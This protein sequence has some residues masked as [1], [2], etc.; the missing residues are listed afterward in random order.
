MAFVPLIGDI[1]MAAKTLQ[2]TRSRRVVKKKEGIMSY[3][4]SNSKSQAASA[5]SPPI[6]MISLMR[7]LFCKPFS[8]MAFANSSRRPCKESRAYQISNGRR[9]F[10]GDFVSKKV[11]KKKSKCYHLDGV[12][13]SFR[14]LVGQNHS[15]YVS[16][17]DFL[18]EWCWFKSMS[19]TMHERGAL[20]VLC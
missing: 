18:M 10:F 3:V 5:T 6:D 17:C 7:G 15:A 9:N 12:S 8:L 11:R 14:K 13:L 20:S 19:F 1:N 2:E 4:P 16:W